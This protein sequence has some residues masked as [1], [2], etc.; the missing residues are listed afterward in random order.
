[1]MRSSRSRG[2]L[3]F[4]DARKVARP[5]VAQRANGVFAVLFPHGSLLGRRRRLRRPALSLCK[6]R[7]SRHSRKPFPALLREKGLFCSRR[8]GGKGRVGGVPMSVRLLAGYL[9]LAM[10]Y[11]LVTT[12]ASH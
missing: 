10:P 11:V 7:G 12:T 1:M 5:Y 2:E 6:K 3:A 8:V 9:I 4:S